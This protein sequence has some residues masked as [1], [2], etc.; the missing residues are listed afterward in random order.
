[1]PP[2][3]RR[4]DH[5]SVVKKTVEPVRNCGRCGKPLL[6]TL[7]EIDPCSCGGT[8]CTG[9]LCPDCHEV[10]RCEGF[11]RRSPSVRTE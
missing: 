10:G 11:S 6:G 9:F 7:D 3:A 4:R 5:G 1:M 8:K 2:P